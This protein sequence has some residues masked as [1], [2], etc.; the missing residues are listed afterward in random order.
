MQDLLVTTIVAVGSLY[1]SAV[2]IR[3]INIINLMVR[4]IV[5]ANSEGVPLDGTITNVWV[6]FFRFAPLTFIYTLFFL[7][8]A[9]SA[10]GVF[11]VLRSPSSR[12]G[13][14]DDFYHEFLN[15][16]SKDKDGIV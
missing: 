10:L 13:V 15:N 3:S 7:P 12:P 6:F 9:I 1:L 16:F 8:K 14:F 11:G 2:F 4:S 5:R